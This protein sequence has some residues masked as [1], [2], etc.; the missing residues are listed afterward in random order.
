MYFRQFWLDPALS[1]PPSTVD[2]LVL[3]A[4]HKDLIWNPDAFFINEREAKF[5]E[6]TVDN[7]LVRVTPEGEV[8]KSVR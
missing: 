3:P 8:L 1:F 5:H 2:R 4:D 6:A 7:I